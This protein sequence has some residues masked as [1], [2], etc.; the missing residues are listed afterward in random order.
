MRRGQSAIEVERGAISSPES[1]CARR[2]DL[3]VVPILSSKA[4]ASAIV[5]G[6][7]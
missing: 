2:R 1:D 7:A 5:F 3:S 6:V 4:T